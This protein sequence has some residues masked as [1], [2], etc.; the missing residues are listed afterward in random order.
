MR[1]Q[2]RIVHG[3]QFQLGFILV[4]PRPVH[5]RTGL[6]LFQADHLIAQLDRQFRERPLCRVQLRLDRRALLSYLA[7]VLVHNVL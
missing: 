3:R 7:A 6:E 2:R 1:D 4:D 5:G